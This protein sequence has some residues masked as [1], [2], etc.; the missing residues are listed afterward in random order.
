MDGGRSAAWGLRYQYLRTLEALMDAVE[1]PEH[2]VV[3]VHV[4]GLPSQDGKGRESIDYEVTDAEGQFM[5]AVQVK[6]RAPG[7][8]LGAGQVFRALTRLA[9][10]R[11]ASSYVL[12]TTATAGPSA[13]DLVSILRSGLTMAEMRSAIDELLGSVSAGE[14]RKLLENLEDEHLVRLSRAEVE[15]DPRG[16]DEVAEQLKSRLRWYRNQASSGLG[17][18]SAGL[19]VDHL[20]AE[21]FRKA[22]NPSDATFQVTQFREQVMSDG[23]V[24]ASAL[25]KRDW[26]IALGDLPGL[27][28]VRRG[29]LLA[30][31]N[32]AFPVRARG[33]AVPVC[34]LAGLSGIGKSSLAFGYVL[35]RADIYDAIFWVNAE[36]DQTL[37]ASFARVFRR[38]RGSGTSVPD[39]V[40]LL[41]DSVLEDLSSSAGRWLLVLDN[42]GELRRADRWVPRVGRG[43]VIVTTTD[44]ASPPWASTL[45]HVDGM[46]VPQAVELLRADLNLESDPGGSRLK[47]LA[48]LARDLECWPLALKLACAYLYPGASLED[49]IADYLR[50]LRKIGSFGDPDLVPFDYPRPL[51]QAIY[52]CLERIREVA[53][54][55]DPVRSRHANMA[56]AVLRMGAYLASSQIPV[57]L[58][59]SA[60][61][62]EPEDDAF[63][64]EVPVIADLED[65]R[66]VDVLR[67]LRGQSLIDYGERLPPYIP[68]NEDERRYDQTIS[69]N[70]VIQEVIQ[71]AFDHDPD[72]PLIIDR[73]AW[74]TERWLR[75]AMDTLAHE[76]ALILAGHAVAVERHASRLS[77]ES[78]FVALLRGNLAVFQGQRNMNDKG[79]RLLRAEIK[80]FQARPEEHARLLFFQASVQLANVLTLTLTEDGKGS[81]DEIADLLEPGYFYVRDFA[82]ENPEGAA[83]FAEKILLLLGGLQRNGIYPE[84]LGQLRT[85]IEN[86][87]DRL[88]GTPVSVAMKILGEIQFCMNEFRDVQ[89]AITLARSLLDE[90]LAE[91][92]TVEG[93]QLRCQARKLLIEAHATRSEFAAAA[94]EFRYFIEDAQPPSI[95][96]SEI[97]YLVENAG[98]ACATGILFQRQPFAGTLLSLLLANG[99]AELVEEYYPGRQALH[100]RFLRGVEA[101]QRRDLDQAEQYINE[102]FERPADFTDDSEQWAGWW[103]VT[104]VLRDAMVIE[105][106]KVLGVARPTHFPHEMLGKAR[107]LLLP[108]DIRPW[109][110]NCP[111]EQL[112]LVAVLAVA[113][114]LKSLSSACVPAC[115]Q[116][117]GA[118]AHLGIDSEMVA[119]RA[120]VE[121]KET[122]QIQWIGNDSRQGP[123]LEADGHTDGHAVLW[124]DNCRIMVDPT[125]MHLQRLHTTSTDLKLNIPV[126][127]P[128]HVREIVLGPT[129]GIIPTCRRSPLEIAWLPQPQW[130]QA[131]KPTPATNLDTAIRYG[132]LTLAHSALELI[133]ALREMR[134]DLSEATL[135]SICPQLD[136]VLEGRMHLPALPSQPPES[137]WQLCMTMTKESPTVS[138]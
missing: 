121:N 33:I 6:A 40:E 137:F 114:G 99:R 30:R 80:H 64:S 95:H 70:S 102:F 23:A 94:Q 108:E 5:L 56:L 101:F 11:N 115:C 76:R 74:H 88:P 4:E 119:V 41:R 85:A 37:A 47:L 113:C 133:S 61:V 86:I 20:I 128:I 123:E 97:E 66:P 3:A 58:V 112:T 52:L 43:H 63:R 93:L 118:L 44:S 36:S 19:L 75:R 28:T 107:Y 72:T 132:S 87:A 124:V 14:Q 125:I 2:G 24:V 105:R 79:A 60:P 26:G 104:Q 16:D 59:T 90:H 54:S 10:A 130:T 31:I 18:Q 68:A 96:V 111:L 62:I 135:S 50:D 32:D 57:Y 78:D 77:L 7:T 55:G 136:D 29:E 134:D 1:R 53:R 73:L 138:D 127:L 100:V 110:D 71:H 92:N 42:C 81:V 120:R 46:A 65:Q 21:V 8:A 129:T 27:P 116:L 67:V 109:L 117:A 103:S 9:T 131:I 34:R 69:V 82:A 83:F 15:F 48:R 89:R 39:D 38:L 126:S 12:V 22:A 91:A 122:G 106:D 13:M 35:D 49:D 45:I 84:R 25:G 98:L 17:D 51:I